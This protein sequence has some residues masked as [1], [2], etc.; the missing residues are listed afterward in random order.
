V[1]ICATVRVSSPVTDDNPHGF[2]VINKSDM[3]D[4]HQLFEDAPDAQDAQK[5]RAQKLKSE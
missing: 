1:N 3:T 5:K 4:D 2:I